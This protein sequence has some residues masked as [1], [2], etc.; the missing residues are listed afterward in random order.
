[1]VEVHRRCNQNTLIEKQVDME[2]TVLL[3]FLQPQGT[4]EVE[5]ELGIRAEEKKNE[6]KHCD[7]CVAVY[8]GL[9]PL[10]SAYSESKTCHQQEFAIFAKSGHT[11]QTSKAFHQSTTRLA[12]NTYHGAPSSSGR[13]SSPRPP[14]HGPALPAVSVSIVDPFRLRPIRQSVE[15]HNFGEACS[16]STGVPIREAPWLAATD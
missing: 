16:A 7:P 4:G 11:N 8:L 9:C 6:T 14:V 3:L 15:R 10:R 2:G 13:G 12:Y 1:M 5:K